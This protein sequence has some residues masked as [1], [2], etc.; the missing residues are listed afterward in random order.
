M[1]LEATVQWSLTGGKE[2]ILGVGLEVP[3]LQDR[4]I[5]TDT[6]RS[7]R[8]SHHGVTTTVAKTMPRHTGIF[9]ST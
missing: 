2:A 4:A 8:D 5:I 3:P 1:R 9:T 7:Y 6:F